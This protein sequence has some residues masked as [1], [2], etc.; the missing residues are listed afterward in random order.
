MKSYLPI[1][2][3]SFFAITLPIFSM[4]P[5]ERR[6]RIFAEW[7]QARHEVLMA[8]TAQLRF[9]VTQALISE[10]LDN[11]CAKKLAEQKD[12]D[13]RLIDRCNHIIDAAHAS[14]SDVVNSLLVLKKQAH[15][16]ETVQEIDKAMEDALPELPA[17]AQ[18]PVSART[19]SATISPSR[20]FS[21]PS[22]L[23]PSPSPVT[24][25][26]PARFSSSAT[27]EGMLFSAIF[28]KE[29]E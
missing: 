5:E 10:E 19:Y 15:F 6:A 22:P 21:S 2:A 12:P 7:N 1:L 20:N 25:A 26:S 3:I 24:S 14:S 4:D 16:V 11:I 9:K 23:Q 17:A 8:R 13:G 27:G 29:L 28:G 18:T